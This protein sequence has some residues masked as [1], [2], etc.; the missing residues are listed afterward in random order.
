[1]STWGANGKAAMGMSRR[2][3][4]VALVPPRR[5]QRMAAQAREQKVKTHLHTSSQ[6]CIYYSNCC[7]PQGCCC[8]DVFPH[9]G[10]RLRGRGQVQ[11]T[12]ME[13]FLCHTA[14]GCISS[15]ENRTDDTRRKMKGI[16][17]TFMNDSTVHISIAA[18]EIV[19]LWFLPALA[20]LATCLWCL[21]NAA[22]TSRQR[23]V[24]SINS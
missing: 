9:F 23:P 7:K 11:F 12:T 21:A 14:Q 5:R 4:G 2:T 22:V 18:K 3:C 20:P 16:L 17:A 1:M 8:A 19:Q 13:I 24:I 15:R 10:P 6:G